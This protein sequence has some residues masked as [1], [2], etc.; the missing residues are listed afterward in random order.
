LFVVVSLFLV[1]LLL[2]AAAIWVAIDPPAPFAAGLFG[3]LVAAGML[4][5]AAYFLFSGV[6]D[7]AAAHWRAPGMLG[8]SAFAA[9]VSAALLVGGGVAL[10]FMVAGIG[11]A[12]VVMFYRRGVAHMPAP[13]AR[14]SDRPAT[15]RERVS[16]VGV[17]RMYLRVRRWKKQGRVDWLADVAQH[18]KGEFPTRWLA[19][20]SLGEFPDRH[21]T[22]ALKKI[23]GRR[24]ADA[25]LRSKAA[26][27]LGKTADPEALPTLIEALSEDE[28]LIGAA[29]GLR[30]LGDTGA[31]PA[32]LEALD[33]PHLGA[34]QRAHLVETLVELRA[35]KSAALL[36]PYLEAGRWQ[37]RWAARLLGHVGTSEAIDQ[38]KRARR[39]DPLHWNVYTKALQ[40]IKRRS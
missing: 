1:G 19:I 15:P 24:R 33:R 12:A 2:G 26:E 5:I 38:I 35:P 37:R 18:E 36:M 34:G 13:P 28:T 14:R 22:R 27:S 4:A 30:S 10:W 3:R 11:A 32:L 20:R 6:I 21:A 39:R 8:L 23:V 40:A 29:K 7:L 31:V 9:S 16:E 17:T 25:V